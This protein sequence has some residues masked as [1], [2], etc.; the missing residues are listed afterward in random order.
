MHVDGRGW[1]TDEALVHL[2]VP[3]AGLAGSNN[4]PFGLHTKSISEAIP[5]RNTS[6]QL[7]TT[8]TVIDRSPGFE[9]S[10]YCIR[11]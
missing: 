9:Y 2:Q 1:R 10:T 7:A 11:T 3:P 5:A 4:S 6:F 8:S